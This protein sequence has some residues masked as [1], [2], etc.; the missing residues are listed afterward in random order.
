MKD[1]MRSG[2]TRRLYRRRDRLYDA[3][4]EATANIFLVSENFQDIPQRLDFRP[5]TK[6][7]QTSDSSRRVR[8]NARAGVSM[9]PTSNQFCCIPTA[10]AEAT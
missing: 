9:N 10:F 4:L 3:A 6:Q 7:C 1:R 2:F 8:R 5:Y